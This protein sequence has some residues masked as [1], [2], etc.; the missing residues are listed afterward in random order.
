VDRGRRRRW[1]D[2]YDGYK[3]H[4]LGTEQDATTVHNDDHR[5]A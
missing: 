4:F 1:P 5:H 2:W 3:L